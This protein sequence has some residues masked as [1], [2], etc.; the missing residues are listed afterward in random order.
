LVVHFQVFIRPRTR[1]SENRIG[2]RDAALV[3]ILTGISYRL[4]GI[5]GVTIG[6]LE[7]GSRARVPAGSTI[8]SIR[9]VDGLTPGA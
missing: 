1:V 2:G 6:V 4:E 3:L 9:H 8:V 5:S 7:S